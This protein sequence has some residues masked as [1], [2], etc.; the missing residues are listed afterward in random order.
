M[1]V[2]M[3]ERRVSREV[4]KTSALVVRFSGPCVLVSL[5]LDAVG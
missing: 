3:G 1:G 2:R 5:D 4:A